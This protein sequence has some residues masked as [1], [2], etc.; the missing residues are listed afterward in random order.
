MRPIWLLLFVA[1]GVAAQ[2]A[3][4]LALD[5]Y[6]RRA[7]L[8]V[9]G[10]V[11]GVG[12]G[13]VSGG[14]ASLFASSRRD[15]NVTVAAAVAYPVG[16]VLG[17]VVAGRLRGVPGDWRGAAGG[18]VGGVFVGAIGAIV[19]AAP[20]ALGG[21]GGA[22][23]LIAGGVLL[24]GPVFYAARDYQTALVRLPTPDGGTTP[25]VQLRVRR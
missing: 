11:G 7:D 4:S 19:V 24:A 22:A 16:V 20:L 13:L 14:V 15:E 25:G 18:A 2:D 1:H 10:A 5:L 6:S 9:G 17:V 8:Y 21:A 23:I 3:D 12:L